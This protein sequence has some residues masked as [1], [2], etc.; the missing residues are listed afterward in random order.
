MI[1]PK[2]RSVNISAGSPAGV[3]ERDERPGELP[4]END[5]RSPKVYHCE[6]PF[7]LARI[8]TVIKAM[9]KKD[10]EKP[11]KIDERHVV[12]DKCG[13]ECS[14]EKN[15]GRGEG[16]K[17]IRIERKRHQ[18]IFFPHKGGRDEGFADP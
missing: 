18:W 9:E 6:K 10:E 2:E 1:F 16:E 4:D 3:A 12:T 15:D 7:F 17:N 11:H 13:P 8:G 14:A 5:G